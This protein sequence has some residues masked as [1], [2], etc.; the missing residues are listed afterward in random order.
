MADEGNGQSTV[1]AEEHA[2]A[3]EKADRA[4]AEA[5]DLRRQLA[6]FKD[7][8]PDRVKADR[9]ALEQLER[10]RTKGDPK[11]LEDWKSKKEGELKARF[12]GALTEKEKRI[13]EL[14]SKLTR[15]EVVQPSMLKAAEVFNSTELPLVQIL[16]E[17][18][19]ALADGQI[20][21]RGDDGKGK[22]SVRNPRENMGLDEYFD[23]LAEKHPNLAK[24]KMER[25]GRESGST[26]SSS[27]SAG[28]ISVERYVKM[29]REEQLALPQAERGK[30]AAAALKMSKI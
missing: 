4:R 27:S 21:V 1:T 14:S 10:E 3:V 13:E 22:P 12:D 9:D 23:A 2:K 29:S 6:R 18:D 15:L 16:V 20:V 11:A 17:R 19:L 25:G 8:D 7:I 30:L 24:P 26:S 28:T 5:E